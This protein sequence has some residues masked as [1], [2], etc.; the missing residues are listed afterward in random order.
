MAE[1]LLDVLR[2]GVGGGGV[3]DAPAEAHGADEAVNGPGRGVPAREPGFAEAGGVDAP[4]RVMKRK[5][6]EPRN[7]AAVAM[8]RMAANTA[9][10]SKPKIASSAVAGR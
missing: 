4:A 3:T 9:D 7:R 5:M 2:V 8:P 1:E 10:R 6:P